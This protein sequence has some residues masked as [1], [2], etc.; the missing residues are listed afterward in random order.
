MDYR[1]QSQRAK[2]SKQEGTERIDGGMTGDAEVGGGQP[3]LKRCFK[4]VFHHVSES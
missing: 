2:V 1:A 3:G 4:D